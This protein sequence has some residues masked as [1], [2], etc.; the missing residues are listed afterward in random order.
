MTIKSCFIKQMIIQKSD[1]Y[2]LPVY[3]YIDKKDTQNNKN[4]KRN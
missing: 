4:N 2:N 3:I 1:N